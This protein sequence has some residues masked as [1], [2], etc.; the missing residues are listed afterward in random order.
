[1]KPQKLSMKLN[2]SGDSMNLPEAFNNL[3]NQDHSSSFDDLGEWLN[4]N[5]QKPGKMKKT[6]KIAA[7]FVLAGLIFV[8]CTVPVQQEE[9]IGYMI[10]GLAYPE[11]GHAKA[12]MDSMPMA[13]FKQM[14]I[15][16]VLHDHSSGETEELLE[17][18]LVL[19]DSDYDAALDKKA[20]LSSL[21]NFK[22]LEILAMGEYVERPLYEVALHKLDINLS[23]DMPDSVLA[24]KIDKFVFENSTVEGNARVFVDAGG[25]KI[26]EIITE[27]MDTS[28]LEIRSGTNEF[29]VEDNG[30]P[31]ISIQVIEEE[32][33]KDN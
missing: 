11:A 1:M 25:Y 6:Y 20:K 28:N 14:T 16:P 22:S 13:E 32:K 33:R 9:E 12:Q 5:T 21:Y 30:S 23:D 27:Q 31:I 7:S 15:N 8:A 4:Q 29:E 26:V 18:V 3:K 17:M 19:P 10:K 2:P 24:K